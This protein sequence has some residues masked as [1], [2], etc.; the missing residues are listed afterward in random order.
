MDNYFFAGVL[1]E[2]VIYGPFGNYL[3]KMHKF[4]SNQYDNNVN[5]NY[6]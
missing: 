1:L 5:V 2:M 6:M 3:D 4:I